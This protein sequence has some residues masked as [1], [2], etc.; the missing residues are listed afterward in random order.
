MVDVRL[1][2]RDH[3]TFAW[4]MCMEPSTVALARLIL[5]VRDDRR[6]Y[7]DPQLF[8][9][10]A[11]ELLL[12]LFVAAHDRETFT[13]ERLLEREIASAT[14]LD[15]WLK[16]LVARGIVDTDGG[17]PGAIVLSADAQ[18]RMHDLL[19]SKAQPAGG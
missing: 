13:R 4:S 10:Q 19:L 2:G 15:R 6:R 18:R 16:L 7:F 11:W 9:E 12:L 3:L 14:V 8:D 5:S 1:T 17:A